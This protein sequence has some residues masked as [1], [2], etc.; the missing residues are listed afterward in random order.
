MF[1]LKIFKDNQ[2]ITRDES[3]ILLMSSTQRRKWYL[4]KAI[5]TKTC[6]PKKVFW[7]IRQTHWKTSLPSLFL[8][9]RPATLLKKILM[10]KRFSVNGCKH[11]WTAGCD[12]VPDNFHHHIWLYRKYLKFWSKKQS[13]KPGWSMTLL[14]KAVSLN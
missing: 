12:I 1:P 9:C 10:N 2:N 13:E 7:N 5:T 3:K 11:L 8:G 6:F 4:A 14:G